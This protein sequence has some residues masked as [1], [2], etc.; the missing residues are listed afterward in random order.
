MKTIVCVIS[1]FFSAASFAAPLP[2]PLVPQVR[3]DD[4]LLYRLADAKIPIGSYSQSF[5]GKNNT[6]LFLA[7]MD[8]AY[9]RDPSSE[10]VLAGSF[11]FKNLRT[12]STIRFPRVRPLSQDSDFH[13]DRKFQILANGAVLD[14]YTE[15]YSNSDPVNAKRFRRCRAALYKDFRVAKDFRTT[16]PDF[17]LR[18]LEPTGVQVLVDHPDCHYLQIIDSTTVS[19]D[20]THFYLVDSHEDSGPELLKKFDMNGK[21]LASANFAGLSFTDAQIPA[22]REKCYGLRGGSA[23]RA[24]YVVS[25][26]LVSN[27]GTP[28]VD[29]STDARGEEIVS[30]SWSDLLFHFNRDLNSN[31]PPRPNFNCSLDGTLQFSSDLKKASF[32]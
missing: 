26:G 32:H 18:T 13:Y 14:L 22:L 7:T 21:L 3:C 8:D 23:D 31:H 29:L 25:T 10:R 28:N 19:E 17:S 16:D 6:C 15:W 4:Q 11:E 30:M 24:N 12:F 5:A 1:L 2:A 20:L 27:L 9:D